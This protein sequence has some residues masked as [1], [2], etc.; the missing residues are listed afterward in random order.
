ML[1]YP[2]WLPQA[3]AQ[4]LARTIENVYKTDWGE[5]ASFPSASCMFG[6]SALWGS[7][8]NFGCV[9]KL[10]DYTVIACRG[11]NTLEEWATDG[12]INGK[13]PF[14]DWGLVHRGFYGVF[15]S[16]LPE[17]NQAL[18]EYPGKPLVVTGHSLG[19]AVATLLASEL[20][21]KNLDRNISVVTF[22]SPKVG[23]AT[24]AMAFNQSKIKSCR[25][26]NTLDHIPQLPPS[27]F[28]GLL[29]PKYKHVDEPLC[30]TSNQRG[31]IESHRL[32]TYIEAL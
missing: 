17:V 29:I 25:I 26:F 32:T 28:P 8:T 31:L 14:K 10:A 2:A 1:D 22:G 5:E 18:L 23:D 16:C 6:A 19:A 15:E 12:E 20:H 30:F 9:T 7:K 21:L 13:I 27:I 11:T 4:D 24:F 3:M